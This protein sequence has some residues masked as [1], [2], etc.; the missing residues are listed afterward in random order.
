MAVSSQNRAA[1]VVGD[2]DSESPVTLII[3]MVSQKVIQVNKP[4]AYYKNKE[5]IKI[6]IY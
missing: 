5:K 4:S 1:S 6:F 3:N 2:K